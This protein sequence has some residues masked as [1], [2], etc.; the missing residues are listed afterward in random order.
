MDP[1]KLNDLKIMINFLFKK[2]GV[3]TMRYDHLVLILLTRTEYARY[4]K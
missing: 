3:D 4:S 2:N 1:I